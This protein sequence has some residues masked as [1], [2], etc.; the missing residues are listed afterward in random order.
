M[1][2]VEPDGALSTLPSA[3]PGEGGYVSGLHAASLEMVYSAPGGLPAMA[4]RTRNCGNC[5]W[6][7]KRAEPAI[8]KKAKSLALYHCRDGYTHLAHH[9]G[10]WVGYYGDPLQLDYFGFQ[11]FGSKYTEAWEHQFDDFTP[12]AYR[13]PVFDIAEVKLRLP[14][15]GIMY[16]PAGRLHQMDFLS[17]LDVGVVVTQQH[18]DEAEA[19]HGEE[20]RRAQEERYGK[21]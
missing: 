9:C 12:R 17:V 21:R 8:E 3:Y 1:R 5:G 14:L 13:L 2:A 15:G 19:W 11:E 10:R 16:G 7:G 4:K 18:A 6:R 20:Y